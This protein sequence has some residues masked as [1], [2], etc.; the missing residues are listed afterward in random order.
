MTTEELAQLIED[1]HPRGFVKDAADL[2][3]QLLS[4]IHI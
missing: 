1:A 2:L 3:R 4:L